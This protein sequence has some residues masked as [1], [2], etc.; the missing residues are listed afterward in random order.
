M[1]T[2]VVRFQVLPR[3]RGMIGGVIGQES[4]RLRIGGD[5]IPV[6]L[7]FQDWQ[8]FTFRSGR[9]CEVNPGCHRSDNERSHR[10][11]RRIPHHHSA[12]GTDG[13]TD[14][15]LSEPPLEAR[16]T[17]IILDVRGKFLSWRKC[18]SFSLRDCDIANTAMRRIL[19]SVFPP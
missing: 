11:R 19:T 5:G 13:Q 12:S 4:Q 9:N 1:R 16:S 7:V 10:R 2:V 8:Q 15:S 6:Q 18:S 14:A 3:V 17:V